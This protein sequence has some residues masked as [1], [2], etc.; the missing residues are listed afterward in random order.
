MLNQAFALAIHDFISRYISDQV[1]IKWPNDIYVGDNKI[2]GILIQNSLK[3][4]KV[5]ST[6]LGVGININSKNFPENLPNPTSL[7]LEK[8]SDYGLQ[9]LVLELTACVE[10][11]LQQLIEGPD[12]LQDP[13]MKLLYKLH[14]EH[15]FIVNDRQ[16]KGI[17]QG[18]NHEGKL[19]LEISG[20]RKFFVFREI[21][22]LV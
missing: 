5:T 6:I 3:T 13:Y 10:T 19:E 16:V 14:E 4:D 7:S 9:S 11:R 20:S 8:K 12:T 15:T 17:I 22:F 21:S 1:T 18:V 2:A